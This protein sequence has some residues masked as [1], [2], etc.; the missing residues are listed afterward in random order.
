MSRRGFESSRCERPGRRRVLAGVGTAV[1]TLAI[2]GCNAVGGDD[3][4]AYEDGEVGAVDG[5]DRTPEE[6]VAAAALAETEINESVTPL[7]SLSIEAH[8]FVLEDD[9]RG[10]TVQGTVENAGDGRIQLVE[11]RVRT[12]DGNGEQLGRY[13]A[14]TGDLDG[15]VAWAFEVILL[16]SVEDLE[17][18]D[19]T[20]L[21]TPT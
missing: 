12:Y 6:T 9:F 17:G 19:V 8:E 18:Y 7:D 20:V 15:G 3:S 21:G 14:T 5:E 16:E 2:A 10:P 4:P 11:V 1:A 13:L